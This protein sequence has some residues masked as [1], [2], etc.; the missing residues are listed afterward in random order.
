MH[1]NT[2]LC[3]SSYGPGLKIKS[4][5][6]CLYLCVD[7]K[8]KVAFNCGRGT[9]TAHLWGHFGAGTGA[10]HLDNVQC[11]GTESM[12]IDCTHGGVGN[13]NC[14][15][16]ED[17]GVS[18]SCSDTPTCA[19]PEDQCMYRRTEIVTVDHQP[20][21]ICRCACESVLGR[22]LACLFETWRGC[23][24]VDC[25][26]DVDVSVSVVG[27]GVDISVSVVGLTSTCQCLVTDVTVSVPAVTLTSM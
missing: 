11:S 6:L 14:G 26:S 17:A 18:C 4:L 8:K 21:P 27:H 22:P 20:C 13:H 7:V 9:G 3:S 15:H 10:I 2:Q 16:Y 23:V 12:L 1:E 19:V 5:Y 24:R 25:K